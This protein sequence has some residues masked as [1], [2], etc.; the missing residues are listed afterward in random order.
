MT[1]KELMKRMNKFAISHKLKVEKAIKNK[2]LYAECINGHNHYIESYAEYE[3]A[4]FEESILFI[5][6]L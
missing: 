4:I 3:F 5:Y 6:G 1:D 2:T